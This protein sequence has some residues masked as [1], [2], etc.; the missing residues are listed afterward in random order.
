M[1]GAPL[2]HRLGHG[3]ALEAPSAAIGLRCLSEAAGGLRADFHKDDAMGCLDAP[4]QMAAG[5]TRRLEW[6]SEGLPD[7]EEVNWF[8]VQTFFGRD[9]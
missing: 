8:P 9:E 6:L 3:P 2:Y 4:F 5:S 7:G 1:A